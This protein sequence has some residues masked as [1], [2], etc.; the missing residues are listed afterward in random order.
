MP[1][2]RLHRFATYL[3]NQGI[4]EQTPWGEARR[5][6]L[7]NQMAI[8]LFLFSLAFD[9]IYLWSQKYFALSI[10]LPLTLLFPISVF[11]NSRKRHKWARVSF[12]VAL[13]SVIFAQA[14]GFGPESGYQ[15]GLFVTIGLPLLIFSFKEY[16]SMIWTCL[17]SLT[18]R[19]FLEVAEYPRELQIAFGAMPDAVPWLTLTGTFTFVFL[20]IFYLILGNKK[21]EERLADSISNLKEAQ[22]L[23]QLGRW[24]WIP[25]DDEVHWSE[26]IFSIYK[27]Q[28][29]QFK[30]TFQN[31]LNQVHPEDREYV[32]NS[33]EAAVKNGTSFEIQ[34][35]VILADGTERIL[36]QRGKQISQTSSQKPRFIGTTQDI[37]QTVLLEQ[38]IRQNEKRYQHILDTI[39]DFVLVKGPE[40]R[41]IW[42]NSAFRE[43]YGMTNEQLKG[44]IDAPFSKPDNT[45]QYVKDD[46]YVFN[47]GNT[48]DIPEE[49]V[50][51]HDGAVRYFHTVKSPLFNQNGQVIM[52]VGISRDITERKESLEIIERERTKLL[53]ASKMSALGEM[54]SGIAHEINNPLAIIL[55]NIGHLKDLIENGNPDPVILGRIA[56]KVEN[57]SLRIVK[58][59]KSLRSF[60]RDG[61][62]D[63]FETHS[64]KIIIQDTLE[65]CRE[66]FRNHSVSLKISEIPDDVFIECRAVQISQVILNLLNNAY[67]AVDHLPERWVKLEVFNSTEEISIAITDSGS[68]IPLQLREKIMQPFFTTKEI[69]RGTGLGLSVSRGIIES[70]HGKLSLDDNRPNTTFIIKLPKKQTDYKKS[71]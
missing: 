71:A 56:D 29:D 14:L 17:L 34:H 28:K 3:F 11:L 33:L 8:S 39:P 10:L 46:A 48:L 44:I 24:D 26:E 13:N 18:L 69:G 54:S 9:F 59:V 49:P 55:G 19:L 12:I 5:I 40:S 53:A 51:R 27:A 52:T 38:E 16:G 2:K 42:A 68:G 63:P 43:Y 1:K 21:I 4:S 61:E 36:A 20:E 57:T 37:T 15:N 64:L 7:S 60:A 30:L 58:I 6:T 23:A 31:F 70:H 67:D 45:L 47:T 32:K 35:R 41:L 62:H 65:F 22:T 66:R 50:V 25:S